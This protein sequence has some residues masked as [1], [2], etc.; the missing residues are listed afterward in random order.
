MGVT[1]T[2]ALIYNVVFNRPSKTPN[3]GVPNS[4]VINPGSGQIRT[5]GPNGKPLKDIDS[6]HDHGQGKPHVHDWTPERDLIGRPLRDGE[7]PDFAPNTP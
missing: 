3:D 7:L 5:Y 4:T 6:D 1:A 2:G